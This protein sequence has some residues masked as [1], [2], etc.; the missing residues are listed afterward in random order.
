MFSIFMVGFCMFINLVVALQRRHIYGIHF[1]A[2][3]VH[4]NRV[5]FFFL[6]KIKKKKKI[7]GPFK[8]IVVNGKRKDLV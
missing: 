3:F 7:L 1:N 8:I 6:L 4:S 2:M 5:T